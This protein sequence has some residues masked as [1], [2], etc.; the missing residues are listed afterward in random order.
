MKRGFKA[1]AERLAS[2]LR[3]E[4]RVAPDARLD[5]DQLARHLGVS[6]RSA[7]ELVPKAELERL[8]EFSRDVLAPPL[9]IFPM[10]ASWL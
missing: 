2:R 8:Y 1:D 10:A 4:M 7:D 9:S 3:G 6:V 5:V